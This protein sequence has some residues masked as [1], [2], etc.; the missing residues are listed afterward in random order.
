VFIFKSLDFQIGHVKSG[1]VMPQ[2]ANCINSAVAFS[3]LYLYPQVIITGTK[4]C[5]CT[6]FEKSAVAGSRGYAGRRM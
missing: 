3:L 2:T 1:H 4:P 5:V 6:V